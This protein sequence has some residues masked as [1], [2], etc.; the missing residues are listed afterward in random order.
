MH[1]LNIEIVCW[2][3]NNIKR[4]LNPS[5]VVSTSTVGSRGVE[6][7][8]VLILIPCF[9]FIGSAKTSWNFVSQDSAFRGLELSG[10]KYIRLIFIAKFVVY[11]GL[12]VM[13]FMVQV[14][15]A[16]I[17]L[18]NQG[19]L[20]FSWWI[21]CLDIDPWGFEWCIINKTNHINSGLCDYQCG[22]IKALA[23]GPR[24]VK[25]EKENIKDST[26]H[27]TLYL[28]SFFCYII[29]RRKYENY[30][31]FLIRKSRSLT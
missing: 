12:D 17:I 26:R 2:R 13:T 9:C 16:K 3:E 4:H 27:A 28:F 21:R 6:I 19:V 23:D 31:Y 14:L 11:V 1:L 29:W 8:F 22:G 15:T 30:F 5:T 7:K 24:I 20:I 25:L 10:I 18:R